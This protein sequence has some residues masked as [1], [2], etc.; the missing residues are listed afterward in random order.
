MQHNRRIVFFGEQG[1]LT[2]KA[3]AVLHGPHTTLL[4][5]TYPDC[6]FPPLPHQHLSVPTT[7]LL[8]A[9]CMHYERATFHCSVKRS[10]WLKTDIEC[11]CGQFSLPRTLLNAQSRGGGALESASVKRRE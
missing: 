10:L 2:E 11:E 8:D 4:H 1:E 3:S 9:R 7:A 5:H 6:H